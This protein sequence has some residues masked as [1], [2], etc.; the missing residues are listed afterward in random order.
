MSSEPR[1]HDTAPLK[2]ALLEEDASFY[3]LV[4]EFVDSLPNRIAE[5]NAACERQDLAQMRILVHRLKGA[6][7][8]FGYPQI[9][10]LATEMEAAYKAQQIERTAAWLEQLSVLVAGAKAGLEPFKSSGK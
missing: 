10:A 8:S 7:G 3:E 1:S 2:S 9:T 4:Q 6:G 5:L